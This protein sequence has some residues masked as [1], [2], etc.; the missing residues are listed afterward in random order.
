MSLAR[1]ITFSSIFSCVVV[2]VVWFCIQDWIG[3]FGFIPFKP[4]VDR[5]LSFHLAM[6]GKTNK[7]YIILIWLTFV[8]SIWKVRNDTLFKGGMKG[9]SDIVVSAKSLTWNWF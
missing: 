2:I 3:V 6:R 7:K 1:R 9:V 5:L 4:I 8:R